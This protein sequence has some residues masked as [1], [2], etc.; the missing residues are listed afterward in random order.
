MQQ[1]L[2]SLLRRHE[3]QIMDQLVLSAYA[4]TNG[5][6][7]DWGAGG[8]NSCLANNGLENISDCEDQRGFHI[9]DWYANIAH[10]LLHKNL[11]IILFQA[12]LNSAPSRISNDHSSEE[13]MGDRLVLIGKL[14]EGEL[15]E[16]PNALI[17]DYKPINENVIACNF[18]NIT[19]FQHVNSPFAWFN[20]DVSPRAIATKWQNWRTEKK[21]DL[22]PQS[23]TTVNAPRFNTFLL[24][25]SYGW[26]ISDWHWNVIRPFID[27]HK[28]VIGF[29]YKEAFIADRV[30]AIGDEDVIPE[31]QLNYLR[32]SGCYVERICGD[33]TSIATL[34]AER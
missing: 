7:L 32:Q 34:L 22:K 30:Y 17:G 9:A 28:P 16:N 18:W 2:E 10:E 5:H 21:R 11:P 13:E 29:S 12:G 8:E 23:E 31:E 20:P 6:T 19:S 24:L 25:P 26:G 27:K 4:W 3:L 1:T 14:L 15:Q 33:G